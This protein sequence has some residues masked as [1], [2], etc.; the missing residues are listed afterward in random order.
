MSIIEKLSLPQKIPVGNRNEVA[1]GYFSID[2]E[3]FFLELAFFADLAS[4]SRQCDSP[5]TIS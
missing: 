1:H 4:S 2:E 3:D 5:F